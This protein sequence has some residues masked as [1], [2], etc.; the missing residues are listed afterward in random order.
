MVPPP[1]LLDLLLEHGIKVTG[2][3]KIIDIFAGRGVIQNHYTQGNQHGLKTIENLLDTEK[4]GLFFANLVDFDMLYGHRRNPQ[5][6]AQALEEF[7][8]FL[9]R[10]LAKLTGE[11]LLIIT[12]DHGCDPTF[13]AHTDHTRE[14]VP[15]L[16]WKLDKKGNPRGKNL[17][18]RKG[19][20]DLACTIA[21]FF[22]IKTDFTGESFYADL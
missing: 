4:D 2:V 8:R 3:G 6:Y 7:D 1:H 13:S 18:T 17:G 16:V 15:L 14:Y 10:L 19:F 12:A 20:T 21:D 5:G 11:D 9:P 22:G